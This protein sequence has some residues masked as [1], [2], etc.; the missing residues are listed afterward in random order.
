M[1]W[2]IALSAPFF[3]SIHVASPF[4][5]A[6]PR[7][8]ASGL[9]VWLCVGHGHMDRGA[10]VP[11]PGLGLESFACFHLLFRSPVIIDRRI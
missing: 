8:L 4:G 3:P 11:T 9:A 10:I 2:W 7:P 1:V 5:N 6:L